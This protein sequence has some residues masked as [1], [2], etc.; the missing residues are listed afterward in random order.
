M[1]LT[2][3]QQ[4]FAPATIT[5]LTVPTAGNAQCPIYLAMRLHWPKETPPSI[6]PPGEGTWKLPTIQVVQ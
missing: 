3:R 4:G 2:P 6:L 1:E 5:F